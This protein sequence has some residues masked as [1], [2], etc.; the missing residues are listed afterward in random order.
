MNQN[1]KTNTY[2]KTDVLR[3]N[4]SLMKIKPEHCEVFIA[5]LFGSSKPNT[6]CREKANTL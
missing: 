1:D 4:L 3:S 6:H 5:V 2:M